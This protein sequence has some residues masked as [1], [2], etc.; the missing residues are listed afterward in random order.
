MAVVAVA[1]MVM[2]VVE[3][4]IIFVAMVVMVVVT[5]LVGIVGFGDLPVLVL[6]NGNRTR[7]NIQQHFISLREDQNCPEGMG[8]S[9]HHCCLVSGPAEL[10]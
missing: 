9:M 5:V 7:A 2:V 8:N 10:P 4:V 3:V 6:A 1:L